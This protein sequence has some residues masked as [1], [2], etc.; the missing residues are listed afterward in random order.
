[1]NFASLGASRIV[2]LARLILAAALGLALLLGL[3][4]GTAAF[5][6]A[7]FAFT[8]Y[9]LF[10]VA[11]LAWRPQL[12]ERPERAGLLVGDTA[13]L[14][15]VLIFAPELPA[16]FLLFFVYFT[17]V[18]GLWRGW[19]AAAGLSVLVSAG[20][21]GVA[22]RGLPDSEPQPGRE[23]LGVA[24]ALLVAGAIVGGVAERERRHIEQTGV[25]EKYGA[26][27]SLDTGWNELWGRWLS[28]LCER[29]EASRSL[30][31]F[32]DAESGHV[33]LW[34]YQRGKRAGSPSESDR[35]PRDTHTFLLD[36]VPDGWMGRH[37]EAGHWRWVR[38]LRSGKQVPAERFSLPGRFLEEFRPRAVLTASTAPEEGRLGRV[39]LLD[40]PGGFHRSQ[41]EDLQRLLEGLTPPLKTLLT[42]RGLIA[43]ALN[44]ERERI[45]R[46]LHDGVAQTLASL[47]M[48]LRVARR[49]AGDAAGSLADEVDRLRQLVKGERE[50]FR[51]FLRAL[52]P[53]R[54]PPQELEQWLVAHAAQFQQE[55]GI[56]VEVQVDG[57]GENLPEGIC[58]EVFLI[59]REALHN[60]RKHAGARRVAV[61]LRRDE[62][63]LRLLVDDDG[64]GF[65]FS[66]TFAQP[67]LEEMG[68]APVSICERLAGLGAS[69]SIDSVPGSGSALRMDI[70]LS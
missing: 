34:N 9:F 63:Y 55:T 56:H 22:W 17:L 51:R 66:G 16:A 68:F 46:D 35:P 61:R 11:V 65:P 18:A 31:V 7:A 36:S 48:Q 58:R 52:K 60:I 40:R 62:N 39:F 1:M 59:V 42:V 26:L 41:L 10:A 33:L 8:V 54:V 14:V 12:A 37:S 47:E 28:A 50:E 49:Q 24:V 30:W 69:L 21:L 3:P 23:S 70:P 5:S 15:V 2:A 44:D 43:K 6:L 29:Y 38:I 19:R 27:L 53:I 67:A 13:V 64:R 25:V 32:L 57:L 45:V 20:Y 4:R